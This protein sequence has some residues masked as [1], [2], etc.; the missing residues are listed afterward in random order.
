MPIVH[1]GYVTTYYYNKAVGFGERHD[2][3]PARRRRP[4]NP[5]RRA[6][7]RARADGADPDRVVREPGEA[8]PLHGAGI[9]QS[10][11]FLGMNVAVKVKAEAR[12]DVMARSAPS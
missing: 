2:A 10:G 3:A 11:Y 1:V 5:C 6:E 4:E 8:V 7:H 12:G 9:V